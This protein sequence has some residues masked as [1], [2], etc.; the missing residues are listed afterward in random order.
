M[1]LLIGMTICTHLSILNTETARSGTAR[2][3]TA[4]LFG[5]V[6]ANLPLALTAGGMLV[7]AAAGTAAHLSRSTFHLTGAA[8][9]AAGCMLLIVSR[10]LN[11]RRIAEYF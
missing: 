4:R 8:I 1:I 6:L 11:R 5:A 10:I 2:F 3:G 9:G 7:F